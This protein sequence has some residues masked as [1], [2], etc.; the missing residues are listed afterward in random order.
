M[1]RKFD[2]NAVILKDKELLKIVDFFRLYWGWAFYLTLSIFQQ[3]KITKEFVKV[4]LQAF[5]KLRHFINFK[6]TCLRAM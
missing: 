4:V 2:Q 5:V 6:F 3:R 1:C